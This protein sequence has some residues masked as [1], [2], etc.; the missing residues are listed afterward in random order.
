MNAKRITVVKKRD[1]R[2]MPFTPEK[3]TKAIYKAAKSVG[4]RDY[5]LAQKLSQKVMEELSHGLEENE[6]PEIERIQDTVE[7]VLIEAGHA[8][9]AKAYILYR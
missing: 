1:G 2:V 6:I 8:R 3:I 4:G 9:T 5:A 7:K